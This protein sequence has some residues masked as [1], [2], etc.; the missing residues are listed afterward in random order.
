MKHRVSVED[1]GVETWG[2]T[3]LGGPSQGPPS[4]GCPMSSEGVA[5]TAP[6]VHLPDLPAGDGRAVLSRVPGCLPVPGGEW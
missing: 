1:I 4:L 5:V 2:S 3:E 6:V